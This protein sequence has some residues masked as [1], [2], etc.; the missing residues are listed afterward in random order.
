MKNKNKNSDCSLQGA[1]FGMNE[2]LFSV[3]DREKDENDA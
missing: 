3:T 2:M 1:L